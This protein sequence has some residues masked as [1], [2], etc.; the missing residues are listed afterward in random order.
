MKT[1]KTLVF[2]SESCVVQVEAQLTHCSAHE[3][4]A[5]EMIDEFQDVVVAA[6][7]AL[8]EFYEDR[9]SNLTFRDRLSFYLK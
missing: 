3:E 2:C 5:S 6:S 8:H 9:G 1:S 7:K 4:A